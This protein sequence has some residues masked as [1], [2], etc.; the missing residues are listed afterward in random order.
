MQTKHWRNTFSEIDVCDVGSSDHL[1]LRLW[2]RAEKRVAVKEL[3]V[4]CVC[5]FDKT[6]GEL[7]FGSKS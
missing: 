7:D 6:R 2:R 1:L 5:V 4:W 3:D